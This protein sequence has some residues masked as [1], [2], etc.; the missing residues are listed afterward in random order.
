MSENDAVESEVQRI[1]A[2]VVAAGGYTIG[3]LRDALVKCCANAGTYAC[4]CNRIARDGQAGAVA[5]RW[6]SADDHGKWHT[7][8]PPT[9]SGKGWLRE[10]E[11]D[12]LVTIEYA[13]AHPPAPAA[14]LE[15]VAKV[16]GADEYGPMIEWR[17]HWADLVG[18]E[19]FVGAKP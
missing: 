2:R 17:K 14:S 15:A 9:E 4:N 5:W 6:R 12:Q 7:F 1:H 3:V 16:T 10:N 13:F 8:P 11:A 19:L 18:R